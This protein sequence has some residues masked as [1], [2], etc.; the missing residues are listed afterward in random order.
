MYNKIYKCQNCGKVLREE[1]YE[2]D[3]EKIAL[4][5]INTAEKTKIH[6][7]NKYDI[8]ILE[9]IAIKKT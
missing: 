3:K 4:R 9:L 7:C 1:I 5:V 6:C 8:G 2:N